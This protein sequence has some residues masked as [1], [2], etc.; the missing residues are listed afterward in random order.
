MHRDTYRRR[1]FRVWLTRNSWW[2]PVVAYV[3]LVAL[4]LVVA[5]RA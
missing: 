4:A 5:A 1:P 2:L 3:A